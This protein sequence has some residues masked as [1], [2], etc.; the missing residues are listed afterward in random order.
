MSLKSQIQE[1]LLK[2]RYR[3]QR[4]L[5]RNLKVDELEKLKQEI[6]KSHAL[7]CARKDKLPKIN[8]N[9]ILPVAQNVEKIKSAIMN[10]Q[11]VII[12][13]DTGSGKTSQIPMICLEAGRGIFGQI[14]HTQPRRIAARSVA[15]RIA[16][17][18]KTPLGVAVG[19]K[20]RFK[21]N[22]SPNSYV[23]VMTDGIL[24]SELS[25]DPWLNNYD[26][27]IIDEAH[28]RSLNIDFLLG[29]IKGKLL[30]RSDLKVIITSATIDPVSFSNYFNDAPII[31]VAGRTYPVDI[32]YQYQEELDFDD[33]IVNAIKTLPD[34]GDVLVFLSG[35]GEINQV[36]NIL[37]KQ[38]LGNTD[39]LP[40]Y[41]RLS[42]QQQQLIFKRSSKRK[43]I[44]STNIAET[45]IT[46]PGIKYVI[47]CGQARISRY[48]YKSRIQR[49]PIERISKSSAKQRAGRCG[50]TEPG[51]CIRLYT[52]E[53][54]DLRDEFSEPE[55][56]RTN[57]ATIILTMLGLHLGEIEDFPFIKSPQIKVIKDGV[58]LLQQIQAIDDK[59]KITKIG[60]TILNF[61]LDPQLGVMLYS[62]NSLNILHSVIIVVANLSIA[63]V[64]DRPNEHRDLAD[65]AHKQFAT[66]TSDFSS[67][68]L[69]WK[70]LIEN[71]S[72]LSV[73][74]F[75]KLC[76]ENFISYQRSIEWLD[77][78]NQ[79]IDACKSCNWKMDSENEN[80]ELMH[81][82]ILTGL[83]TNIGNL[84]PDRDYI[85]ANGKRFHIFPG[86]NLK[87]KQPKW[88]IANEIIETSN[89]YARTVA[90][91]EPEWIIRVAEHLLKYSYSYPI[92]EETSCRVIA[93]EQASIFGLI[94]Y[95][96]KKVN[97]ESIEPS[98]CKKIMILHMIIRDEGADSWRFLIHN[99]KL[100]QEIKDLENRQR[101]T[102][103]L[104]DEEQLVELYSEHI[105]ENVTNKKSFSKWLDFA[106]ENTLLFIINNFYK[107]PPE[108]EKIKV[109]YPDH[110]NVSGK[111]YSL[112][113]TF[114]PNGAQDGVLVKIPANDLLDFNKDAFDWL[115]PG[116][117]QEKIL[118]LLKSLPKQY[119]LQV[120]PIPTLANSLYQRCSSEKIKHKNLLIYLGQQINQIMGVN[121][122]LSSWSLEHI[123]A[124]LKMHI[125]V[126]DDY[127]EIIKIETDF[128]KLCTKLKQDLESIPPSSSKKESILPILSVE[129]DSWDFGDLLQPVKVEVGKV[130]VDNYLKIIFSNGKIK[131]K[132]YLTSSDGIIEHNIGI[133]KLMCNLDDKIPKY[134][135]KQISQKQNFIFKAHNEQL[136]NQMILA[137][138]LHVMTDEQDIILSENEFELRFTQ[139]HDEII[140]IFNKLRLLTE[141][142]L[143]ILNI[144]KGKLTKI[145]TTR[146]PES[147]ADLNA[148][149]T[150][151]L[152]PNFLLKSSFTAITRY[153]TYLK[154]IEHRLEKLS[155][156]YTNDKIHIKS[157]E[158]FMNELSVESSYRGGKVADFRWDLEELRISLF[159]QT[160]KTSKKISI[161]RLEKQLSEII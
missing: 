58:R 68:L 149:M 101:C 119:R 25:A 114:A 63:D 110:I 9:T 97:Y 134:L 109:E 88:I 107:Y 142:S 133:C 159:A 3:F 145:I 111:E 55:I 152:A 73:N 66:Q 146:Y 5:Q 2:D 127:G 75:K 10:N 24:L 153:P 93:K 135:H 6:A 39:V 125:A 106:E 120:S 69:I 84:S 31:E 74:K 83:C 56:T 118:Q 48:S 54:Y 78:Y 72:Q 32:K 60:K 104:V 70:F 130:T 91:I 116:F 8:Y 105:P 85:G 124:Y 62:A 132:N 131:L 95:K 22:S 141:S 61:P 160:L 81:I 82:S 11:V 147:I 52:E 156:N 117:L 123:P 148:Q 143:N 108:R 64:R 98:V 138:Y 18:L 49:L 35:E 94:L 40:L 42:W 29:I 53:D 33:R 23:K 67:I 59:K 90:K 154:A 80:D 12:A 150:L 26:T 76:H 19:Y 151:L 113:Y 44:L 140:P 102:D 13:G 92:W 115:V 51:V 65:V 15:A 158:K 122:P 161:K 38:N 20:I 71:K 4:R 136:P 144:I 79:L 103:L 37:H 45:S 96:D 99:R 126:I 7:V 155:E 21:D 128:N 17:E 112:E 157:I 47:D 16:D 86:S 41:S 77:V 27:I 1:C 14:A 100:I 57:L 43:I 87:K 139:K 89:T 28:E 46:V 30:R 121:I 129:Y 36:K 34:R 137:T 50:R